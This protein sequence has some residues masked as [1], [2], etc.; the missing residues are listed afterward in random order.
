MAPAGDPFELAHGSRQSRLLHPRHDLS[1]PT[2]EPPDSSSSGRLPRPIMANP[3]KLAVDHS[4][5]ES[6]LNRPN[7]RSKQ[8]PKAH[9]V[10]SDPRVMQR[11]DVRRNSR[12][13][14]PAAARPRA[15]N[16]APLSNRDCIARGHPWKTWQQ[17]TITLTGIPSGWGTVD[18][19]KL[20]ESRQAIPSRIDMSDNFRPGMA[21]VTFRPPP[22]DAGKWLYTGFDI[23]AGSRGKKHIACQLPNHMAGNNPQQFNELSISGTSLAFGVMKDEGTM[24]VMHT[25]SEPQPQLVIDRQ[26][27]QLDLRFSMPCGAEGKQSLRSFIFRIPFTQLRT[28]KEAIDAQG[29]IYFTI[30]L[31]VPP[32]AFRKTSKVSK[33][34]DDKSRIWDERQA[35]YRQI[36][37]DSDPTAADVATRTTQLQNGHSLVDIGRWLAYKFVC[38]PST[39][40]TVLSQLRSE[41]ANYNIPIQPQQCQ[42]LPSSPLVHWKWLG[43]SS[44]DDMSS[45]IIH[46]PFDLHYQ[47]E[48]C[49]SQGCFHESNLSASWAKKLLELDNMLQMP[50]HVVRYRRSTKLLEKVLESKQRYDNPMDIFKFQG[51]VS[52]VQKKIPRYC[53]MVRSATVTPTTIYFN[54]PSM[55]T[56]NRV[57]RQYRHHEDR[58]LRVKFRDES[59][60]GTIMTFDD[61]TND[62]LF[63]HVKRTMKNGIVVGDRRYEFLAYGNSQFR[64]HGAYFFAPTSDLTTDMIRDWMGDFESIKVVAKY[65]SRVG[66]CFSTTRAMAN[67]L[68]VKRI[69]DIERNGFCFTDGVG[70][71]STFLAMM[72]AQEMGL[73]SSA[74]DCPSVYQFRLG[75]SKGVL[76]IDPSLKGPVVELR[77]SQEKFP[78][79]YRGLEICRISQFATA[80]LNQQIV[81]VLSALGVPDEIFLVKLRMMLANLESAMS[82]QSM[83]LQL[84]QKNI[85][86]NQTTVQIASMILDGF[87]ATQ[88]PFLITCL[89]LWRSWSIKYLK[90]KAKI[91][92]EQGAFVLGCVDET[93]IL[94]GHSNSAPV[95]DTTHDESGLPEV[96][97]QIPDPEAEGKFKVIEGVCTLARN[98]SLHPGDCRVVKAVDVPQLRHLR[99]C[100]V[101][102]QSGD[103]DIASMCSGGDLDGDDYLV[104]WDPELSPAEWNHAPMDY[105]APTPVVSEG[106]V[107][108]DAMTSFFVT[109][110][111]NDNLGRIATAHRYWADMLEEGV[112]HE[113]CIELAAL[114]SKAVDYAKTGAP[115]KM[116]KDL[117]VRAWP[118]WAEKKDNRC[119][120]SRKILGKL[121]DEVVRVPFVPAWEM[122]FDER[123]LEACEPDDAVLSSAMEVKREYDDAI[124]RLMAQHGIQSEFEVWTTFVMSHNGENRDF[125]IAEVLGE[126]VA[127]IKQQFQTLCYERA[128]TTPTERDWVK[129]K[130]FI[131]AMYTV[132][133]QETAQA[134]AE[135][136]QTRIVAG[137]PVPIRMRSLDTMPLIS[138]PW[139][140]QREL[141]KIAT[142]KD[143]VGLLSMISVSSLE[144]VKPLTP[145]RVETVS[146]KIDAA[147]FRDVAPVKA[148]ADSKD[149]IDFSQDEDAPLQATTESQSKIHSHNSNA[150][151]TATKAADAPSCHP[152]AVSASKSANEALL[153]GSS[154]FEESDRGAISKGLDKIESLSAEPSGKYE[155]DYASEPCKEIAKDGDCDD[156]ESGEDLVPPFQSGS[157]AMAA[158]DK[159]AEMYG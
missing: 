1:T 106:P 7:P 155:N 120:R 89:R 3:R 36:S 75:G 70:K 17:L 8:S 126:T 147:T 117:K 158:L 141:G 139:L 37:I 96:F 22:V 65:A 44:T 60:K 72:T 50:D 62:E 35:W 82:N 11:M 98:P 45:D 145:T 81:L 42:C 38:D 43:T 31:E 101:L 150:I 76:T 77:P 97:L 78:A 99:N 32:L 115:A 48:A 74:N 84:L 5:S 143:G 121:Y 133:A 122:A 95:S 140:F 103:R 23:N 86:V 16:R 15:L 39:T 132:T 79:T 85:D 20:L 19:Y 142:K 83:A 119:Y 92:V 108:V 114:H 26:K 21:K 107:T 2:S 110:M 80:Y 151:S 63:T 12:P 51:H 73:P 87:M 71:I 138:F 144:P 46:L 66:Q 130:P 57:I 69:D 29:R 59:Y 93:G 100:V 149:L 154:A 148:R 116:P 156:D 112:K 9:N 94:K 14:F 129:L 41:L 58:F 68:T 134:N 54:N 128:G 118:H 111:K 34:H 30:P 109:H 33:T 6:S 127:G 18:V 67:G 40:S 159:L 135:C 102:P 52:L 10:S 90:E 47:V 137:Q 28:L 113:K 27:Q 91:F 24:L 4:S 146:Q 61:D 152:A 157:F 125:K 123:I 105:T 49:I 88:D 124:R 56:S 104:M 131:V 13:A 153:L 64:E 25:V 55:D 53:T 136:E